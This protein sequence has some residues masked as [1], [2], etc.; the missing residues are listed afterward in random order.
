MLALP[1]VADGVIQRA[2]RQADHLRPDGDAAL[3]QRF[4]SYLVSLAHLAEHIRFRHG[5]VVQNQLAGGGGAKAELVLFLADLKA[6]EFA[7]DKKRR[8]A[9]IACA[10][11][12]V[13]KE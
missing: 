7:L 6:R 3:I 13:G 10:G 8:D 2:A 9:A 12:G 11:I 5:A 1:G 4:D